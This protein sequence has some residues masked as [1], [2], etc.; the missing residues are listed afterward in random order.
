MMSHHKIQLYLFILIIIYLLFCYLFFLI[1]KVLLKQSLIRKIFE[2]FLLIIELRSKN[3]TSQHNCSKINKYLN[4]IKRIQKIK[5]K[6]MKKRWKKYF[7]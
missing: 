7:S 2:Y 6:E 5:E 1:A 3:Q 4:C